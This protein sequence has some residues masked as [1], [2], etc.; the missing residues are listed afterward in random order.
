MTG[1]LYKKHVTVFSGNDKFIHCP[2]QFQFQIP[3]RS[4]ESIPRLPWKN[5]LCRKDEKTPKH[6]EMMVAQFLK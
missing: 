1:F 2:C 4:T 6:C 3:I 5:K